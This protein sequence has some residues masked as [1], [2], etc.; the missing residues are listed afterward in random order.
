MSDEEV[1]ELDLPSHAES[2]IAD[3][4][5][6]DIQE[7]PGLNVEEIQAQAG[8]LNNVLNN[9][10]T[11]HDS[12]VQ[13]QRDLSELGYSDER[14]DEIA[15]GAQQERTYRIHHTDPN[16]G[17]PMP[18]GLTI[19]QLQFIAG[20]G[21]NIDDHR[22]TVGTDDRGRRFILDTRTRDLDGNFAKLYLPDPIEFNPLTSEQQERQTF[23]QEVLDSIFIE[24]DSD[25]NPDST[26][27]R[28]QRTE[29][30]NL[31]TTYLLGNQTE[32]D[33][34]NFRNGVQQISGLSSVNNIE[35]ILYNYFE[36][37]DFERQFRQNNNG[38]PQGLSDQQWDFVRTN[39]TTINYNGEPILFTGEGGDQRPYF[40]LANGTR[41][42][43]PSDPEIRAYG[44][45]LYDNTLEN[46]EVLPRQ[47]SQNNL[48]NI[49]TY[50]N[51]YYN[52][53]TIGDDS[54]LQ[55][56]QSVAGFDETDPYDA[57][58]GNVLRAR[59]ARAVAERD[60]RE[61]NN[62]RPSDLSELQ[63]EFLLTHTLE[64]GERR[65]TG[66][67][68]DRIAGDDRRDGYLAFQPSGLHDMS[69]IPT[70]ASIEE[71]IEQGRYTSNL[72]QYRPD[73]PVLPEHPHQIP[74][75][76]PE[77]EPVPPIPGLDNQIPVIDGPPIVPGQTEP[78]DPVTQEPIT[79]PD[80]DEQVARYERYFNDNQ[81]LYQGFRQIYANILP[82]FTGISG[83]FFAFSIAKI[84]QR[85]TIKAIVSENEI[86]LDS[87][88][89]KLHG[90]Q[91]NLDQAREQR[92]IAIQTSAELS[93]DVQEFQ[94]T[95]SEGRQELARRIRETGQYRQPELMIALEQGQRDLDELYRDVDATM[96][97]V[98]D[99]QQI[100]DSIEMD[101]ANEESSR[102][103]INEKLESLINIDYSIL[104][105]LTEYGPQV[106]SGISIGTTLGLV[107][108][109]Y[110][111]PTYINIDDPYIKADN[112]E[113]RPS[114]KKIKD[115]PKPPKLV[116]IDKF[117]PRDQKI[118]TGPIH[119]KV[120]R[121][122]TKIFT[123]YKQGIKPLTYS[124]IQEYKQTLS[125]TELNNL[126]DK[127]LVF[128]D[129]G[130]NVVPI[131]DNCK[132]V[133]KKTD[134]L[135]QRKIRR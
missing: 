35:L 21:V 83:G 106:V 128:A 114:E 28:R 9:Y 20:S 100:V 104:Q 75:P 26:F 49:Q 57:Q 65:Y 74:P 84:R 120:V 109:G 113:Y 108:S 56:L 130:K 92:R 134:L 13:L 5:I 135:I 34:I 103:V 66:E 44:Q 88:E 27:S 76:R 1:D 46:Q 78:I 8:L 63:Y 67:T 112:I 96:A 12:Y 70:D 129:D 45:S 62:G 39:Q 15:L 58:L 19:N 14:V 99:A 98:E 121:P 60:F 80:L 90:L 61:L 55:G 38:R 118:E 123:P 77:V 115:E 24:E 18:S 47:L 116:N 124:Q 72:P 102:V 50:I 119:G 125:G 69:M 93:G 73:V 40:R 89:N 131:K 42:S 82:V 4:H 37:V 17:R 97:T 32:D 48:D 25:T 132:N 52:D 81:E 23:R 10:Y 126:R 2:G 85:N 22:T 111:Y 33:T 31:T 79:V 6:S 68:I 86:L 117:M 54:L 29:I 101:L 107:L 41:I 11:E 91:N 133:V 36:D 110:L 59:V 71:L 16:T 122:M 51:Q 30:N 43:I 127:F 87:I 7:V 3:I 64:D 53:Y 105:S 95:L 94:E